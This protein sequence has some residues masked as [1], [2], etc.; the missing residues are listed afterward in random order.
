MKSFP[1][2]NCTC[3]EPNLTREGETVTLNGWVHRIRDLG[4]LFFADLRDRTGIVQLFLDPAK[5]PGLEALRPEFCL[6]V[7]GTITARDEKDR[8]P[9]M[10][11][12]DV[13]IQVESFEVLSPS[14]A[15]PF[16]ISDEAHMKKVN[17]ELRLKH[18]YLD[19]RRPAMHRRFAIRASVVRRIRNFLDSK[20]FMEVETPIFTKSTPEGARDYLVPYRLKPGRFYALPQSPQQYKQLLMVGGVERYYQIAKCFR[21]EAQRAD[22]QPEFTQLDLEMSFI[23]Q[24]DIQSLIQDLMRET[25]NGV[26]D[27]FS[28][29]K[30]K[31]AEFWTLTYDEA[32][33]LY[34]SDKPDLRFGL[35]IW[36]VTEWAAAGEFGLFKSAV[37]SGS[38]VRGVRRPGGSVLSRKQVSE[39][40]ELAKGFGAK[41]MASLAV[42]AEGQDAE[43]AVDLPGGARIKSSFAKF[44]SPEQ[45]EHLLAVSEAEAGDLL[46]FIAA[47]EKQ[48]ADIL[49]RLRL[50]IGSACG[51]R[52]NDR[53]S[54]GWV[55][56]FP[57]LDWSEEEQ[58]WDPMHH[59]FTSPKPEEMH[60]LETD[61]GSIRA[62]AYDLVCNGYE[63]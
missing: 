5:L 62:A 19:L 38:V 51:L 58:R 10:A 40:E 46:C 15:L 39:L 37:E 61:P 7:T 33:R 24:A 23:T 21:D 54:F 52:P 8:N 36:D 45:L 43:G 56:D 1:Q 60:K 59:P 20:G 12:G 26:I 3:G 13:D 63:V 44:F 16:Q 29:E 49:G 18:R 14:K 48:A 27:E 28:L 30:Q 31:V 42:L 2:R 55:V 53:F 25:F 4:G 32:I 17:E 11:T 57:L 35:P 47:P 41:G 6:S 34:G 50:V 22:R 9:K